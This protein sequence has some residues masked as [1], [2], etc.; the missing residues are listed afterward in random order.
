MD[1]IEKAIKIISRGNKESVQ[2]EDFLDIMYAK[3]KSMKGSPEDE[4]ALIDGLQ[5]I[6]QILTLIINS[7]PPPIQIK[8]D[9]NVIDYYSHLK[10][11]ESDDKEDQESVNLALVLIIDALIPPVGNIRILQSNT[12]GVLLFTKKYQ[13]GFVVEFQKVIDEK[14]LKY[15]LI[16]LSF[17]DFLIMDKQKRIGFRAVVKTEWKIGCVITRQTG[18]ESKVELFNLSIG[19]L[20]FKVG[21]DEPNI[22]ESSKLK[23]NISWPD[24]NIKISIKAK[25]VGSFTIDEQM[26]FRCR[27]SVKSVSKSLK[28]LEELVG[29]VQ[30]EEAKQRSNLFKRW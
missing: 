7:K 22:M 16:Q 10:C 5:S 2:D 14:I 20:C 26:Y 23:C 21:S 13:I 24:K 17:P 4:M 8:I 11:L 9:K 25:I 29:M 19:G 1:I 28:K 27:F 18:I 15:K 3:N 12:I 6:Y 30:I